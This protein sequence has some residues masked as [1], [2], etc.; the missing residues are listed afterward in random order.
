MQKIEQLCNKLKHFSINNDVS[1]IIHFVSNEIR[2][3]KKFIITSN[4]PK[5]DTKQRKKF[6]ITSNSPKAN[7]ERSTQF[8]ITSPEQK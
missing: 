3:P 4:S 8:T 5:A 7:T 1:D 6:V 2:Q